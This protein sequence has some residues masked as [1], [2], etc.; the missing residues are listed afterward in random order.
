MRQS[1]LSIFSTLDFQVSRNGCCGK[2]EENSRWTGM[3]LSLR[4]LFKVYDLCSIVLETKRFL[5]LEDGNA[6]IVPKDF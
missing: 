3:L 4:F 1:P 2:M 6:L 5:T